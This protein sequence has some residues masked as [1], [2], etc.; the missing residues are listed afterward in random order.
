MGRTGYGYSCTLLP[1]R[2]GR[3]S[4]TEPRFLPRRMGARHGPIH[5]K[6]RTETRHAEPQRAAKRTVIYS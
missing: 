1:Q 3:S 2:A 5:G 4:G 6:R